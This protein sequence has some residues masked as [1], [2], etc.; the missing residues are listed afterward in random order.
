MSS[1]LWYMSS[2]ARVIH[3]E[4]RGHFLIGR[5]ALFWSG[6][7]ACG[8]MDWDGGSIENRSFLEWHHE[9]GEKAGKSSVCSHGRG[10][11]IARKSRSKNNSLRSRT[12][13][14]FTVAHNSHGKSKFAHPR[15]KQITHG[16][17]K[18][19]HGKSRWLTAKANRQIVKLPIKI[20][21]PD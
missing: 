7:V 1:L 21:R 6:K 13:C 2:Y 14:W 4:G 11:W 5:H 10:R 15:Q 17:S 9:R 12:I 16:K 8:V 18:F 20:N 3:Q 19:A